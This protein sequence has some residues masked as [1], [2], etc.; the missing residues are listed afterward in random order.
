VLRISPL[1]AA[2][3]VATRAKVDRDGVEHERGPLLEFLA[4]PGTHRR[5][6]WAAG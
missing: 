2:R 5:I 1:A 4:P 3:P 6:E